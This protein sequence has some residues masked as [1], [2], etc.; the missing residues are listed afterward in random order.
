MVCCFFGLGRGESKART[1]DGKEE[2]GSEEGCVKLPIVNSDS[3]TGEARES[4][5]GARARQ[6]GSIKDSWFAE[7]I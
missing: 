7:E 5:C 6:Q 2:Q 3:R 4:T 1:R